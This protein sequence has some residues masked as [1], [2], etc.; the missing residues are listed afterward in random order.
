MANDGET[1]GESSI[2]EYFLAPL[3]LNLIFDGH[4]RLAPV[5]LH[6]HAALALAG[7]PVRPERSA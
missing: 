3:A 1:C 7:Q 5:A 2:R 6:I 4:V